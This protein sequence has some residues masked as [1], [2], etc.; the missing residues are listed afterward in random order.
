[1]D[2]NLTSMS[3]IKAANEL[4]NCDELDLKKIPSSKSSL[5]TFRFRYLGIHDDHLLFV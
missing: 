1:M 4:E 3:S 2:E 5:T